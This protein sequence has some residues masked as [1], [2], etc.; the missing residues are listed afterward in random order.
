MDNESVKLIYTGK[1]ARGL[2][3]LGY[4]IVDVKPNKNNP[5]RTVFIFKDIPGLKD[6][7]RIL[8]A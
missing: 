1:I 5:E 6:D 4:Q 2:L 3:H 8:T 7:L